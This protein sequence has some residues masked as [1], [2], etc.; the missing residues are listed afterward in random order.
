MS[1]LADVSAIVPYLLS[2]PHEVIM[3]ARAETLMHHDF[4]G[5]AFWALRERCVLCEC[6]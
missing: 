6:E 5:P 3:L 1:L 4:G 2:Q